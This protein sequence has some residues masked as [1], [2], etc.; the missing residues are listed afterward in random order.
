MKLS[1][2]LEYL[3]QRKQVN[4]PRDGK[5]ETAFSRRT[6]N[7]RRSM[8]MLPTSYLID[9][10]MP[11]RLPHLFCKIQPGCKDR[12]FF[13]AE[14]VHDERGTLLNR[15]SCACV[16]CHPEVF[17]T[18]SFCLST[19]LVPITCRPAMELTLCHR[20]VLHQLHQDGHGTVG[21]L[22]SSCVLK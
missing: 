18:F 15:C 17:L 5:T 11:N 14:V 12:R 4:P 1:D 8:L 19:P 6:A 7:S 2:F 22:S 20:K 9:M 13:P 10:D 3:K 16:L 21:T